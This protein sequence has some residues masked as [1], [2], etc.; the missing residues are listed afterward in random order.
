MLKHE[1]DTLTFPTQVRIA[2]AN[3]VKV[4]ATT[5]R[6]AGLRAL[7]LAGVV[8]NDHG[9]F[10]AALQVSEVSKQPR[11]FCCTVFIKTEKSHKRVEQHELGAKLLDGL[12]EP[13]LVLGFFQAMGRH[14][15]YV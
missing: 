11:D 1:H 8:H 5:K 13:L 14:S 15:D 4:A 6:L 2:V 9:G 12:G 7:L 10:E 3:R